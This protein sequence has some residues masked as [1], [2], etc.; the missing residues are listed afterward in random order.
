LPHLADLI[1]LRLTAFLLQIDELPNT[2]LSEDVVAAANALFESQPR[3]KAA[4]VVKI[5]VR[6]RLAL[7]S[8]NFSWSTGDNLPHVECM[9]RPVSRATQQD[10]S[11]IVRP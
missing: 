2:L 11:T 1:H 9:P 4:Q 3:Q 6:I 10:E 8:R 7:K 5:N